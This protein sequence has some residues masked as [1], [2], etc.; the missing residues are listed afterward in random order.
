MIHDQRKIS[1]ERH[2]QHHEELHQALDELAADWAAHQPMGKMF[3]N[4]TIME[5]MEWSYRQT[6]NPE[7]IP[8][9][10]P[11]LP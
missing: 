6:K 5:L 11:K 1:V 2:R 9:G 10:R 3:S 8:E 4:S 7:P